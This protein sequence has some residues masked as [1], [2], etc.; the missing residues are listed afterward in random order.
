[1][2]KLDGVEGIKSLRGLG[3]SQARIEYPK[4]KKMFLTGKVEKFVPKG[5]RK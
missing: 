4:V 5:G 1:M 2:Y 3:A